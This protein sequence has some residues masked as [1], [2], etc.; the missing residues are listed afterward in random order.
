MFEVEKIARARYAEQ[1]SVCPML[2]V[3]RVKVLR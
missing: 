3:E 2:T 1:L